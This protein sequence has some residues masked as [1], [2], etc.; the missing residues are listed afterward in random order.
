MIS[1]A[2]IL[3]SHPWGMPW[4]Q[5]SGAVAGGMVGGFSGFVANSV[6]ARRETRRA[7]R[8]VASALIGEVSA[9]AQYIKNLFLASPGLSEGQTDPSDIR[10]RHFRGERD[11]MPIYRALGSHIGVLPRPLPRELVTWYTALAVCLERAR[12]LHE[13]RL[14]REPDSIGYAIELAGLQEASLAELIELAP[15]LLEKLG[16]C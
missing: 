11:Y 1:L 6:Q 4:A 10:R 7:R 14:Q 12:E 9:L 16:S 5:I 3:L 15:P 2:D 8:N 13:L